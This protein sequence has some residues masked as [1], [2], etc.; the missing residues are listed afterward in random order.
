MK[1]D[2]FGGCT[3]HRHRTARSP[4]Q[5]DQSIRVLHEATI[6]CVAICRMQ[7]EDFDL[8]GLMSRVLEF[9]KI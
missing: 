1:K 9:V 7:K 2:Q 3:Q 6:T 8:N 4:A 5:S